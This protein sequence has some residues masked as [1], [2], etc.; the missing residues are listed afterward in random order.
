MSQLHKFFKWKVVKEFRNTLEW[1]MG[2]MWRY[3]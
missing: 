1:G 3:H 2:R